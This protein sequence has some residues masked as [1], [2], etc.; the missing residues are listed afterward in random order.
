MTD[1]F[2][3]PP[4]VECEAKKSNSA[5]SVRFVV[6]A[7]YFF[8]CCGAVLFGC[9]FIFMLCLLALNFA[10]VDG[11]DLLLAAIPTALSLLSF[12][13]VVTARQMSRQ[14]YLAKGSAIFHSIVLIAF[15]ALFAAPIVGE[16]VG[17][18]NYEEQQLLYCLALSL[19][20]L[21]AG[22]VTLVISLFR[23]TKDYCASPPLKGEPIMTFSFD[24]VMD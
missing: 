11:K 5:A 20:F 17:V 2:Y 4:I 22:L 8:G 14:I 21:L 6:V 15:G 23:Y 1:N 18:A 10:G 13:M 7:F 3:E 24:D 16:I 9:V 19:F 12:W